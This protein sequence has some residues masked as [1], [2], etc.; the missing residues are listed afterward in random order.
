MLSVTYSSLPMS[1]VHM[2]K[3]TD[4]FL[5]LFSVTFVAAPWY[6]FVA[7]VVVCTKKQK[8][9]YYVFFIW[10]FM[11]IWK[12]EFKPHRNQCT[13]PNLNMYSYVLVHTHIQKD[14]NMSGTQ[15]RTE[16]VI[17]I[18]LRSKSI[19]IRCKQEQNDMLNQGITGFFP[20]MLSQCKFSK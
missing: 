7:V 1:V 6:H 3:L 5:P 12:I 2:I 15:Y 10:M 4:Q 14:Y 8:S 20:F 9:V 19:K 13:K 17:H 18:L 16:H 11:H